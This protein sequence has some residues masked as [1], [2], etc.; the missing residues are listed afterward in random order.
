MESCLVLVLCFYEFA[1]WLMLVAHD[2]FN[3]ITPERF[4]PDL[5]YVH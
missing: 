3:V 1:V 2:T 5:N 4:S